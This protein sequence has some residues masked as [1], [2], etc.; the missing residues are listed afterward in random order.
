MKKGILLSFLILSF[1]NVFSQEKNPEKLLTELNTVLE[2][3]KFILQ[4]DSKEKVNFGYFYLK[5]TNQ[6]YLYKYN[7]TFMKKE[8]EVIKYEYN[9]SSEVEKICNEL[10]SSKD[11]SIYTGKEFHFIL[12]IDNIIYEIY[13]PCSFSPKVWKDLVKGIE[14]PDKLYNNRIACIC[15]GACNFK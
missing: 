10:K 9:S 6:A 8:I 13:A 15:G 1:L 14:K 12:F 2:D 3:K 11:I 4:E 7:N 5:G